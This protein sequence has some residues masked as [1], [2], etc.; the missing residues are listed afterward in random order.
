MKKHK[1][2]SVLIIAAVAAAI[3]IWRQ[4]PRQLSC[5][6]CNE[7]FLHYMDNDHI[8]VSFIKDF[9]VNDSIS[10]DVTTLDAVDSIGWA[11]LIEDCNIPV[12]NF[13]KDKA[14]IDSLYPGAYPKDKEIVL[15][16][17]SYKCNPGSRINPQITN[18]R[19][20][21]PTDTIETEECITSL[22]NH[23]VCIF[24]TL[25]LAER[26]AVSS[27]QYNKMISNDK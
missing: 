24:H 12:A 4:W 3:V 10:V 2:I 9:P 17:R 21:K 27:Y 19:G 6:Q 13:E 14:Y 22:T 26:K 20:Y 7:L 16:W 18:Y 15:L 5:T 1:I 25:T 8:N 11:T 23:N